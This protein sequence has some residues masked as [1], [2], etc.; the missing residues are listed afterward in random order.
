MSAQHTPGPWT[1]KGYLANERGHFYI[2][3][4]DRLIADVVSRPATH[5]EDEANAK[6]IVAAPDL[7]LALGYAFDFILKVQNG[8]FDPRDIDGLQ[9]T[10]LAALDKT[11]PDA[12]VAF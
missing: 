10:M 12:E 8:S 1:H 2:G 5:F 3:K 6:L 9:H 4:D 11:S 7:K